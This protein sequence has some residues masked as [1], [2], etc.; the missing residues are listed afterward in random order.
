MRLL[1]AIPVFN[2][3]AYLEPVLTQVLRHASD[4]LVVDDGSTDRTPELLRKFP[5]VQVIHHEKNRGYGASL[6]SA[7]ART[8][9]AGYEGLITLDC[10]G[11]HEPSMIREV[12]APLDRADIVSGSRYL[13]VFD[14]A[15]RPPEARRRINV[16]VTRW[17]NECLGL[18]LTDAFCGFKAYRASALAKFSITDDGYAMPLQVWVQAAEHGM[19]VVEVPVPLI[20]LDESRAFGG[21]LDDAAY[22]LSHYRAVLR[23]AIERSGL[24]VAGGCV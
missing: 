12:A 23:E 9:E 17:L 19:T 24:A 1:T 20:Y 10:D 2:E 3:E 15:Q 13:K 21:A 4:V 6:R 18:N 14:P 5:S 22:R 8:L 11:Q 16:E 7:F